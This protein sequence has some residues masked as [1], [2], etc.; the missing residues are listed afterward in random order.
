MII[1]ELY[2]CDTCCLISYFNDI[3]EPLGAN[4]ALTY[5]ARSLMDSA[6][7]PFECNVKISI[8]SVVFIEIF[9]KWL[10]KEE[11]VKRFYFD[12]FLKLQNSPNIEIKTIEKAVLRNLVTIEDVLDRHEISDK[13]VVASALE[14]DCSLFTTD[15][16]IIE[17]YRNKNQLY[18]IKN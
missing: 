12:A 7:Q 1:R 18:K 13:I 8:P 3:F 10:K 15:T 17:Y 11:N 5:N 14:L 9:D 4:I 16:K 6:I 2:V